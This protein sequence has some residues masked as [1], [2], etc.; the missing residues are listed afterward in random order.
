MIYR[1]RPSLGVVEFP[2][3]L[4]QCSSQP[5]TMTPNLPQIVSGITF[6]L[7]RRGNCNRQGLTDANQSC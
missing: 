7:G 4:A 1:S 3:S 6:A 2:T 5:P